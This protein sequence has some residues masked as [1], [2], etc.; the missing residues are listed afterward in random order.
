MKTLC[1][2]SGVCRGIVGLLVGSL[3]WLAPA[4]GRSAGDGRGNSVGRRTIR[5][6]G[7]RRPHPGDGVAVRGPSGTRAL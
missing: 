7:D 5:R 3:P 6:A 2:P 4:G 1:M